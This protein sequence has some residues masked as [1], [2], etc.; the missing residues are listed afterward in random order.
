LILSRENRALS[1]TVSQVAQFELI[2][3]I[4]TYTYIYED[5]IPK[6]GVLQPREEPALSEAEGISRL[7]SLEPQPNSPLP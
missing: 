1:L 7:T 2:L 4:L 6:R 5:V 3:L